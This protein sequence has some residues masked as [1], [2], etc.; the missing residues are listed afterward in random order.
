[1]THYTRE[2]Q[3]A[4]FQK[5]QYANLVFALVIFPAMMIATQFTDLITPDLRPFMMIIGI[6]GIICSCVSALIWR[7]YKNAA[8]AG[9]LPM[10]EIVKDP[11]S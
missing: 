4:F 8:K 9:K 2:E 7:H 11:R 3:I 5:C 10:P 6:L 1:M